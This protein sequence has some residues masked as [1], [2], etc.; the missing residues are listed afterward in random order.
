MFVRQRGGTTSLVEA[1][2]DPQGR[3]RQRILAN[4]HGEP[5]ILSA[6]AKL[7]AR[8]AHLRNIQEIMAKEAANAGRGHSDAALLKRLQAVENQLATIERDG[9]IIKKYCN[10]TSEEVEAAIAAYKTKHR[11]AEALV[12]GM[13]FATR[14]SLP[15]LQEAK[16]K[17]RRLER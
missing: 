12:L 11:D 13:E 16:A 9:A 5:D 8:R 2:R 4:L 10:A 17:L 6:L 14:R 1:Y 3:S 15:G 7:A